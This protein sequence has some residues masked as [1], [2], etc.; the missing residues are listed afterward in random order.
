M[1]IL[2]RSI[3]RDGKMGVVKLTNRLH[4]PGAKPIIRLMKK[5]TSLTITLITFVT[6]ARA[7]ATAIAEPIEPPRLS[8]ILITEV[9]VGSPASASEEF[10][11]LYNTT[12]TAIDLTVFAW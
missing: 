4:V 9:Q 11:E 3:P 5:L 6:L 8:P 1:L 2:Y 10:I 12:D 7:P